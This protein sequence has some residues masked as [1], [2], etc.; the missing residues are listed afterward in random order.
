MKFR[1]TDS[2]RT[3]PVWNQ[4]PA[5]MKLVLYHDTR[6]VCLRLSWLTE[7]STLLFIK[8]KHLI[9]NMS[10]WLISNWPMSIFGKYCFWFHT[11]HTVWTCIQPYV[12]IFETYS[13]YSIRWIYSRSWTLWIKLGCSLVISCLIIYVSCFLVCFF[14][15]KQHNKTQSRRNTSDMQTTLWMCRRKLLPR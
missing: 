12:W 7:R 14:S 5:A 13:T 2:I 8:L 6:L 10:F 9:E 11:A 15:F 3:T 1:H 4:T